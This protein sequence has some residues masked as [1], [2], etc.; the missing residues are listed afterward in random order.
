MFFTGMRLPADTNVK[1]SCAI[2]FGA[3]RAVST[4][5]GTM[6]A[7]TPVLARM[8]FAS[9]RLTASTAEQRPYSFFSRSACS[10]ERVRL[11][12]EECSVKINGTPSRSAIA[13]S[14]KPKC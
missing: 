11:W 5:L 2:L 12:W 8:F 14:S 10:G 1:R 9:A 3:N 6:A 13:A 4:I 7:S